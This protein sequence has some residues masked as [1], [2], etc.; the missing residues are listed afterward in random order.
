M[1]AAFD[2]YVMVL[3]NGT[4]VYFGSAF[5]TLSTDAPPEGFSVGDFILNISVSLGE[6]WAW[7]CI[8]AGS[9]GTW[10]PLG[11]TGLGQGTGAV[12][13]IASNAIAPTN[14]V[15]HVGA[16]LIKNI[17]LPTGFTSGSVILIPDAAFTTDT[18]GNIS[19]ASTAV[20][21]KAMIMT[22]DGTKWNPSY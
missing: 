10:E 3:E 12:L 6:P 2:S 15:H 4:K 5:P 11:T 1:A 8:T 17:T 21:N 19:L 16:G 9:P 20:T 18:T 22:W 7:R 14:Q 13:T